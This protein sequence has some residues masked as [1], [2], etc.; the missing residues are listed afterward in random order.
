M[1]YIT[2]QHTQRGQK[3]Q[4]TITNGLFVGNVIENPINNIGVKIDD[5]VRVKADKIGNTLDWNFV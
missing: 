1:D 5:N 4:G 3:A 2:I